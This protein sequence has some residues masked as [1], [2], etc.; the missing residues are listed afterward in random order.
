MASIDELPPKSITILCEFMVFTSANDGCV[1][2]DHKFFHGPRDS[3][4]SVVPD[5]PV[6]GI[7]PEFLCTMESLCL[8]RNSTSN[9]VEELS[10]FGFLRAFAFFGPRK[11]RFPI[12]LSLSPIVFSVR[13]GRCALERE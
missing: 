7:H 6:L 8:S 3:D 10:I 13:R 5:V 9:S 2:V 4:F 1:G 12:N 11:S